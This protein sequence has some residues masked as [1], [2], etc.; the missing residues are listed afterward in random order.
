MGDDVEHW[1]YWMNM[2]VHTSS[3]TSHSINQNRDRKNVRRMTNFEIAGKNKKE[4]EYLIPKSRVDLY[5]TRKISSPTL[6]PID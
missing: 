3:K 6:I 2:M 1:N 5:D 4:R